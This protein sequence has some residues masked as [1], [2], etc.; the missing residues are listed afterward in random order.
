M[1]ATV[2]APESP[3]MVEQRVAQFA[4][5]FEAKNGVEEWVLN[6][7]AVTSLRIDRCRRNEEAVRGRIV[8]A[9]E[10]TW[11]ADHKLEAEIL[12]KQ[13]PSDPGR[14]VQALR[15][16]LH[17]CAWLLNQWRLLAFAA[18]K[19]PNGWTEAQAKLVFDLTATP[20]IFREGVEPGTRFDPQGR[21][22]KTQMS[23]A[24]YARIYITEL[25]DQ[26]KQLGVK[27]GVPDGNQI[28]DR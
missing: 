20:E 1:C 19:Q 21:E 15:K 28:D 17:G 4:Q 5:A 7:A 10:K 25:T 13:L 11:E 3:L 2:V 22:I 23:Q 18:E 9:A 14:V 16:T 8:M 26:C 24:D 27:V 6:E 12:A